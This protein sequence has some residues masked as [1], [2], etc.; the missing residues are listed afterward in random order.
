MNADYKAGAWSGKVAI[1]THSYPYYS[2]T[3]DAS[4]DRPIRKVARAR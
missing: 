4:K 1:S 2:L 3:S